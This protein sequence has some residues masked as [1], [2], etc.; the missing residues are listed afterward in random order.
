MK[1]AILAFFFP[2]YIYS[3]VVYSQTFENVEFQ[4]IDGLLVSADLYK[5]GN[6]DDPIILMFHQS[7]SSR[8]EFRTVAPKLVMAGFNVLAVDLR[9]GKKDFGTML[10]TKLQREMEH[11]KLW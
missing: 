5:T 3:S 6:T 8:G 7:A 10:K 2:I 1:K 4:S 11:Y 9:W